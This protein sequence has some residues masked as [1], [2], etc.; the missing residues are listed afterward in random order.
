M[1]VVASRSGGERMEM[2]PSLLTRL[3]R[4]GAAAANEQGSL[5]S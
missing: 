5:L 3:P 4:L 1:K 2:D